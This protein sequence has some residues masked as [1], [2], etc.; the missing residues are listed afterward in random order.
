MMRNQKPLMIVACG[1]VIGALVVGGLAAAVGSG[2]SAPAAQPSGPPSPPP[3]LASEPAVPSSAPATPSAP[4]TPPAPND[5]Q[6]ATVARIVSSGMTV[7]EAIAE[8]EKSGG[9]VG[10]VLVDGTP[11]DTASQGSAGPRFVLVAQTDGD[12]VTVVG[13]TIG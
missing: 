5:A 10:L 6:E 8:V 13:A 4:P 12:R 1:L 3:P 2:S 7:E 9:Y 11:V